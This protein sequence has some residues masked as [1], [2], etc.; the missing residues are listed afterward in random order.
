MGD[1]FIFQKHYTSTDENYSEFFNIQK[2]I[3]KT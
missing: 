2:I 1:I 3:V